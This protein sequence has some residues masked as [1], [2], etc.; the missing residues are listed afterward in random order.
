MTQNYAQLAH[1]RRNEAIGSLQ[2]YLDQLA[3]EGRQM[4]A[5]ERERVEK[6]EQDAQYWSDESQRA[7]RAQ[8]LTKAAD[9]LRGELAPRVEAARDERR[10]ASDEEMLKA[11]FR[12]ESRGF[13]SFAG[14]EHRALQSA[15]GSAIPETFYD[16][17]TVYLRDLTPMLRG[18]LFTVLNTPTGESITLPRLTADPSFGG[19]VTA[20]AGGI[21]EADPT[22]SSVT[23]ESYKYAGITLWSAELGIDNVIGL[24][25]LV[26]RAIARDIGYRIGAAL[27]TGNGTGNPNGIVTAAGNGG[28]AGGTATNTSLDTF[29]GPADLIDLKWSVA[30]GY[31]QVGAY[32]VSTAAMQKIRKFRD[33]N[34][35]FLFTS[36]LVAGM[37]DT[38]D[39]S[40]IVENPAMAAVASAS[41]SVLFGDMSRYFVRR[42]PVR[43]DVSTEYK[44]ST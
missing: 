41:K 4:T 13:T 44:Y 22:L 35:Q 12:G 24:G 17:V 40:P 29:F 1:E 19:T 15:G 16:Q 11:L 23:L 14:P 21:T 42:T 36:S 30:G 31:R 3:V 27:T 8:S 2:Q 43:V 38:F 39:G 10:D 9:A 34:K 25:D 37:P 6:M 7:L 20:E 26:S 32:M 18:D 33:S 28:T 5:E